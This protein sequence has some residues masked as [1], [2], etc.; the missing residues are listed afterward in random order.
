MEDDEIIDEV[1]QNNS[2][3]HNI[4]NIPIIS[5]GTV[6]IEF[7]DGKASGFSLYSKEIKNLFIAY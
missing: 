7:N 1:L 4:Q 6:K 5:K 2:E 3:I